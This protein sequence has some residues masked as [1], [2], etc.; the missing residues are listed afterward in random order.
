MFFRISCIVLRKNEFSMTEM[1]KKIEVLKAFFKMFVK[2]TVDG[3]EKTSY[4]YIRFV[5][6]YVKLGV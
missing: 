4:D 1:P 2:N 5:S 3:S 6:C